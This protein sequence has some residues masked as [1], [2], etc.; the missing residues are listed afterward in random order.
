[1]TG[2]GLLIFAGS[3]ESSRGYDRALLPLTNPVSRYVGD[4][5]YSLYLWH[6]PVAIFALSFLPRGDLYYVAVCAVTFG[7]SLLSYHFVENTIRYSKWLEPKASPRPTRARILVACATVVGLVAVGFGYAAANT[8]AVASTVIGPCDGAAAITEASCAGRSSAELLPS[9]DAIAYD[10]DGAFDPACWR[11]QGES[12]R[13]CTLA[14]GDSLRVALVGDS[15]AGMYLSTVREIAERNSWT[16]D[17]YIGW[18]CQWVLIPG[19]DCL[20]QLQEAQSQFMGSEPYDLIITTASRHVTGTWSD[21]LIASA[22]STWN[23]VTA[24][25]TQ[26]AVIGDAP[27]PSETALECVKPFG[28]DPRVNA[29]GTPS[30]SALELEDGLAEV[31]ERVEDATYIDTTD[32]YCWDGTCPSVIGSVAVCRDAVGHVTASWARSMGLELES[33][34]KAA[35]TA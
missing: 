1:M 26:I 5:S 27:K 33:R 2:A 7:L 21:D 17:T 35:S 24:S 28:F 18:G 20:P 22:A 4:L 14:A 23:E 34:L 6:F 31:S 19:E 12:S 25:G 32:L 9:Y 29:C 10:T 11:D 30:A 3:G 8:T 16:L 15:H 13:S